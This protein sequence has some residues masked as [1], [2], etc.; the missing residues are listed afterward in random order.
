MKK[1][2]VYKLFENGEF[3]DQFNSYDEAL[4]V[5]RRLDK[6]ADDNWLDLYYEIKEFEI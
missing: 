4:K 1:R 3:I 5:K 6:E 2:I